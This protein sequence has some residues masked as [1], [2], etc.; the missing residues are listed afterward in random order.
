M[1]R[2]RKNGDA[3]RAE[4]DTAQRYEPTTEPLKDPSVIEANKRMREGWKNIASV[5]DQIEVREDVPEKGIHNYAP[6]NAARKTLHL[7]LD[8]KEGD[9]K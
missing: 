1:N 2:D 9:K 7:P 5:Y 6:D 4:K 8:G 3:R